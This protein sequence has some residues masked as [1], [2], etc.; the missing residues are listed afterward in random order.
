MSLHDLRADVFVKAGLDMGL[1]ATEV[2]YHP[3]AG[4]NVT[5]DVVFMRDGPGH[6]VGEFEGRS[7]VITGTLR[8]AKDAVNGITAPTSG[9]EVTID[10]ERWAIDGKPDGSAGYWLANVHQSEV[11]DRAPSGYVKERV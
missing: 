10:S 6:E 3:A 2:T 7:D 9:D 1:D 8:F 4:G 11:I 5:I